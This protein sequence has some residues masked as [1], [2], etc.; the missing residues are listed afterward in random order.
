MI[1]VREISPDDAAAYWQLRQ[2]IDR[3]TEFLRFEPDHW[4]VTTQRVRERIEL[5]LA[6]DNQTIF[7][8]EMATQLIGFLWAGGGLYRHNHHRVHILLGVLQAY[9]RQGL[10]TRLLKACEGWGRGHAIQRLELSVMTHNFVALAL[11]H[12]LG[13]QIESTAPYALCLDGKYIDLH[14]MSKVLT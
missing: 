14:Y 8:A 11:Y 9:Q 12:K 6:T 13:F 3:E 7:V 1:N 10:G 2:Q 4:L 5:M